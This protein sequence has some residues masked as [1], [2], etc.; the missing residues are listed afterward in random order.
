M[1]LS[2]LFLKIGISKYRRNK[3]T[4]MRAI[5]LYFAIKCIYFETNKKQMERK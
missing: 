4:H 5:C 3:N 1:K 2:S